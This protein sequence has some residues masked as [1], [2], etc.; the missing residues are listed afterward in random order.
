LPIGLPFADGLLAGFGVFVRVLLPLCLIQRR[1]RLAVLLLLRARL[2]GL[3]LLLLP[4]LLHRLLLLLSVGRSRLLVGGRSLLPLG[5]LRRP[6]RGGGA[7]AGRE[8]AARGGT[9][10]RIAATPASTTA[11]SATTASASAYVIDDSHQEKQCDRN[12]GHDQRSSGGH[13]CA[14]VFSASVVLP[15]AV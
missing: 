8:A 2:L 14:P 7:R 12:R 5:A 10:A 11:A 15:E 6:L 3:L 13:F 1:C 4:V 9:A